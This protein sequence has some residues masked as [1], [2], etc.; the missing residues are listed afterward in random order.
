MGFDTSE[1]ESETEDVEKGVRPLT[2]V[3]YIIWTILDKSSLNSFLVTI[4]KY[5]YDAFWFRVPEM[6]LVECF[7]KE[8]F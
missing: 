5:Y 7:S 3:C 1:S 6:Q 4:I 2:E 8:T